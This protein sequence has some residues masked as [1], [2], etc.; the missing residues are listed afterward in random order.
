MPQRLGANPNPNPNPTPT[1]NSVV[2]LEWDHAQ[3]VTVV[4]LAWRN[5]KALLHTNLLAY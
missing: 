5:G 2:V 1:P 4:E 3:H